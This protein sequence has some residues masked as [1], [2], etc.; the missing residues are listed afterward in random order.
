MRNKT[1]EQGKNIARRNEPEQQGSE[2]NR[3]EIKFKNPEF[4][5]TEVQ[6]NNPKFTKEYSQR[7]DLTTANQNSNRKKMEFL[8]QLTK[9]EARPLKSKNLLLPDY[10][11]TFQFIIVLDPFSAI[12]DTGIR[13]GPRWRMKGMGN[14]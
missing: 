2:S 3:T 9:V 4:E 11:E 13:R 5:P 8:L 1:G 10:T 6:N 12:D 14:G 7:T